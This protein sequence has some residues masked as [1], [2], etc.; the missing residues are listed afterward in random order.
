MEKKEER[1]G[2]RAREDRAGS[3]EKG[4]KTSEK[5][6]K[7]HQRR[8]KTRKDNLKTSQYGRGRENEAA[9]LSDGKERRKEAR[10]G[11][12]RDVHVDRKC[13]SLHSCSRGWRD[14]FQT[15]G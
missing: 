13:E 11:G 14:L 4:K 15:P 5:R 7:T 6:R 1:N 2:G 9:Q 8:N 3:G 12:S 10:K